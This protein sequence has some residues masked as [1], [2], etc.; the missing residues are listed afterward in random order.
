MFSVL[1]DFRYAARILIRNPLFTAIAV[2]TL[3]VGIGAT[4]V[5]FSIVDAFI[6]RPLPFEDPERLVH[7]WATDRERDLSEVRISDPNFI[8]IRNQSD[9]FAAMAAYN[10]GS[11][12][13]Q[14][15][16]QPIRVGISYLTANMF[17]VLGVDPVLG[18]TFVPE[19]GQEGSA[20]VVVLSHSYWQSQYA[21]RNK[22]IGEVTTLEGKPY[23]VI[24]VMPPTFEF[25][26]KFTKIWA[27][28]V[29]DPEGAD[30]SSNGNL[31]VVGRLASGINAAEAESELDV[32]AKRLEDSYPVANRARG[33]RIVPLRNAM[34]FFYEMLQLAFVAG[35]LASFFVLLIVCAN[36]GNL[37]LA[38]ATGRTTEVAIRL[39][40]GAG[41]RR[42]I[43]QLLSESILLA[44]IGGTIGTA[45]A[46]WLARIAESGIPAD[47]YRPGA[48][49]IG[50]DALWFTL[51]IS[52][53]AS[54]VSGLAPAIQFTKPD[55]ADSL[56]RGETASRGGTR[57]SRLRKILVVSEVAM[58]TVLLF[59]ATL[60]FQTFMA[61][62]DVE[63]GFNPEN[64]FTASVSTPRSDY[65]DGEAVNRFH[66]TLLDR[67]EELPG[68]ESA[69]A[70]N[71][72]PLNFESYS[73]DFRIDPGSTDRLMADAFWATTGYFEAVGMPLVRGR[74]FTDQDRVGTPRVVVVNRQMAR[75]YFSDQD[76]IGQI[77]HLKANEDA[78][79]P[80]TIVG[81][82]EDS[83][84]FLLNEDTSAQIYMPLLQ[85]PSRR[86]FL[87]I[88]TAGDPLEI[89]AAVRT[90]VGRIDPL[91]PLTTV[92]SMNQVIAESMQLWSG[93][94]AAFGGLGV[95]ALLLAMMG[96]YGVISFFVGQR[97]REIG[98]HM[99]LGAARRDILK[100]VVGEGVTLTGMGI[101]LGLAASV[102]VGRLV[103]S[104]LYGT[105][106]LDPKVLAATTALLVTSALL[107]CYVPAR[108]AARVDPMI[109]LRHE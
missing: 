22:V 90:E 35:S 82:V 73:Q 106:A 7:V 85:E 29:L 54:L 44:L 78:F 103:G 39:A 42:I 9:A 5:Q 11:V 10:Y 104:L 80:A 93:P 23:E 83:K 57:G 8:D 105:S 58:A 60:M 43:R 27:P 36:V 47:L 2:L 99:A 55:I 63:L 100:I 59:G 94:A 52:L 68:V 19:D 26:L 64:V 62:Q 77:I 38:K 50:V 109:A 96:I 91:M 89:T 75:R 40:L 107:A 24:G 84:S 69:G 79:E 16:G 41:R 70:I 34:I 51:G 48:I 6:L 65:P 18:R 17:E 12:S 88:R 101:G 20:A 30:R 72:L 87:I 32:I 49:G 46:V 25:P 86:R 14:S 15:D 76:P 53:L 108:R 97:Q 33:A 95:A 4:T 31:M 92:R 81:L 66:E 98:I 74:S 21:G 67:I 1:Q 71:P 102:A 56:K 3:A 45:M 28:L 13:L 61:I 37:L